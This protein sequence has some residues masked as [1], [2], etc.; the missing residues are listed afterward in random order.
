M[1]EVARLILLLALAGGALTVLGGA[2]VW[3]LDEGRRIRRSLKKMLGCA[4]HALL[5]ARGR[6][7]GIGFDFGA[8]TIAVTWDGGGWCLLYRLEELLGA[9]L[10]VD[11]QVLARAHRGE[12]RRPLDQLT[13]ADELVR[14]RF[15]FDDPAYPDFDLDLWRPEDD[16]R[17]RALNAPEAV[18]EANRWIA[19]M[20]SLLRRPLP[21][22]ATPAVAQPDREPDP[23]PD[24]AVAGEPAGEPIA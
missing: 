22:R 13:G 5:I 19:R 24:P 10:I 18:Q 2:F 8:N 23:D 6:G 1:D 16:D 15:V 7:K 21:R 12:A 9:E 4:P 11:G 20:D 17:R 14:L 3:F